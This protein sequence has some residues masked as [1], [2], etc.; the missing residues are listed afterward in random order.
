MK[1]TATL[2]FDCAF[3]MG[4]WVVALLTINN[5]WLSVGVTITAAMLRAPLKY[6]QSIIDPYAG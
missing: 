6:W 5:S 4:L 3:F 2:V 1:Y